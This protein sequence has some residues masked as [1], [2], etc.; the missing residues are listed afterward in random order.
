MSRMLLPFL[1][2]FLGYFLL[3]AVRRRHARAGREWT[4][5]PWYWLAAGGLALVIVGL[6]G[7]ALLE[8]ETGSYLPAE[9]R[10]GRVVPGRFE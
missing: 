7:T 8:G 4:D 9:Y 5:A 1:L 3:M 2:P 6:V 10:D